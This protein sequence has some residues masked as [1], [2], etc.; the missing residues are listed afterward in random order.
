M[1]DIFNQSNTKPLDTKAMRVEGGG[2]YIVV[3]GQRFKRQVLPSVA[4]Q[5]TSKEDTEA[6][7]LMDELHDQEHKEEND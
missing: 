1:A 7:A 3:N 6:E 5:S 4:E 2:A